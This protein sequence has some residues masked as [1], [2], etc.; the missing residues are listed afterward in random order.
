MRLRITAC[1]LLAGIMAAS[2]PAAGQEVKWIHHMAANFF[3]FGNAATADDDG[4]FYI[5]GYFGGALDFGGTGLT[6]AGLGDIYIAKYNTQ[7]V[8][9][10]VKQG[11]SDGW[12][13]GRGIALGS[14]GSVTIAGRIE[15]QTSFDGVSVP[16]VGENDVFVARYSASGVIQWAK[17]GGGSGMD[18]ANGVAVDGDGNSYAVGYFSG[19]ATFGTQT[20]NS[21]GDHDIFIVS[22]DPSGNFRWIRSAGGN[23]V[24]EAYGV[25]TDAG[26]N[27]YVIGIATGTAS[28]S[29]T[30]FNAGGTA[31]FLAKYG[32]D[33]S[34]KWVQGAS[35]NSTAESISIDERRSEA[36]V[37]GSYTGTAAFGSHTLT[38]AGSSDI[39]V[40]RYDIASDP[41]PVAGAWS[42]GGTGED[43]VAGFGQSLEVVAADDGTF[44]LA[45]SYENS[46]T[47][48]PTTLQSL[49]MA[50][51]FVAQFGHDGQ[52]RWAIG[53][54]GTDN[55]KFVSLGA[56][57]DGNAYLLGNYFSPTF[58]MGPGTLPRFASVDM[59]MAKIDGSAASG[60]PTVALSRTELD[61]GE[62]VTG[63]S[64]TVTLN[65][66]SGSNVPLTVTGIRFDDPQSES[67]GFTIVSPTPDALP[68]ELSGSDRLTVTV[69]FAPTAVGEVTT[70]LSV[71]TNDAGSPNVKVPVTGVG[72]DGS[73]VPRAVLSTTELDIGDV[74]IGNT[75]GKAFTISAGTSAGLT[76]EGIE[77]EDPRSIDDGFYLASPTD[78][79]IELGAGQSVE[80]KVEFTPE[81]L[82]GAEARLVI[83]SNDESD[84]FKQVEIMA[85]AT[86]APVAV[87]S[88]SSVDF[89]DV[90][91]GSTRQESFKIAG[92]SSGRLEI[93][94]IRLKDESVAANFRVLNLPP[95]TAFP[96]K[97]NQGQEFTVNVEFAPQTGGSVQTTLTIATNDPQRPTT[98]LP[99]SGTGLSVSSV[100]GD[101]AD[102]NAGPVRVMPNPLVT[103]GELV[104]DLPVAGTMTVDLLDLN[105]R[106]VA[107]LFDGRYEG[108]ERRIALN[109]QELPS[110]FYFCEV[111]IGGRRYHRL[112]TISR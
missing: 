35:G 67:K 74:W 31:G 109:A 105:G 101:E 11:T 18:W 99:L 24:D 29:G 59:V 4:N 28:F 84:P 30:N 3:S 17:S 61:A 81:D 52:A 51:I 94:S 104:I 62:V 63:D 43:G 34:F 107:H 7:R 92:G 66:T 111:E 88:A 48:G 47:L 9:Q 5:T 78:F 45:G 21:S 95:D 26:G 80:V 22:Y 87:I 37:T 1:T 10:W 73:N 82:G 13:G 44:Y 108:K 32:P 27:V 39:Y 112:I 38:S 57:N 93:A 98:D 79:P 86:E 19:G 40:V 23:G 91:V 58:K 64:K 16:S 90:N 102:E 55:D 89:G 2:V 85:S 56:D 83:T 68:M 42:I 33:G 69:R 60:Q 75:G 70:M 54:G 77:F 6:G 72:I 50:D 12:N 36:L 96:L 110:G 71:E 41:A 103:I 20:I 53:G 97:L 65:V 14:D 46:V 100:A 106:R 25:A 49:G 15:G 76:I 8:L